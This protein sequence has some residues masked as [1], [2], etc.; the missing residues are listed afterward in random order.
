MRHIITTNTNLLPILC[1]DLYETAISPS[2]VFEW[3]QE[4]LR[5]E[6]PEDIDPY[7]MEIDLDK[8]LLKLVEYANDTIERNV[9]PRL[10]PYGV[11]EIIAADFHHP[12]WYRFGSGRGDDITLKIVVDDTFFA[13]MG[14]EVARMSKDAAAQQY[15]KD[16]WQDRSGFWS[17]MPG[18][19]EEIMQ[20]WQ[21]FTEERQQ[22]AYLTLLCRENDLLWRNDQTQEDSEAQAVWEDT[23]QENLCFSDFIGEADRELIDANRVEA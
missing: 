20:G 4:R 9:L 1:P 8:Y 3:E 18:K 13:M 6:L 7:D 2:V 22:P 17:W 15:A 16:H 23:I 5:E 14:E 12:A 10:R 19:V 21:Y 11:Q